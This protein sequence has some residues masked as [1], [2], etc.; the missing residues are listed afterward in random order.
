MSQSRRKFLETVSAA[1]IVGGVP[2]LGP[3]GLP[4]QIQTDDP[5]GVRGDF[6][7]T[8]RSAYL[9]SPYI[10]PSPRQAVEVAQRFLEAKAEDPISLG[11]MLEE[12][13]AVRQKYA[14]LIGARKEEVGILFATS[15]GENIV[16]R[17]LGLSSGDNVV[18]DD[19][20]YDTTYVL[21]QHLAETKGL[22]VRVVPNRGGATPVDA[23]AEKVDDRTRLISVSWVSHQNGYCHDLRGLAELAHAHGAYLYADA[24][25]GV[26][27]LE[28][29]V[30][31]VGID[32][33]TAGT[34][35]WLLGGFGVAPFFVREELL[36]RISVDRLGA[37]HLAEEEEGGGY[38]LFPDARKYIYATLGFG[39]VYQLSAG[40]DY[41]LEV[42][43]DRIEAHTVPLAHRLREGLLEQGFPVL[44]PEN[45]RSAI[46]T[47]EPGIA[48]E[49]LQRDLDRARIR[50][51]LKDGGT[52]IRAGTALFNNQE[53]VDRLLALT[54]GWASG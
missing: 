8:E 50:V 14:E 42:G 2:R 28:L 5:L 20:H 25:Q 35:K 48:A 38:T 16:S 52:R 49:R 51:S 22:E 34:Y 6:P 18:I 46:V 53:E 23:F 29:D 3:L 19:L 47:F 39:A 17:A 26:G 21:Y 4:K 54:A 9:D 24:I 44:T 45:N 40:L 33:F 7:V 43:V 13:T 11:R 32:F 1:A 10:T 37:L 41:L 12:T 31:E 15:E 27:M 36:E 30:R